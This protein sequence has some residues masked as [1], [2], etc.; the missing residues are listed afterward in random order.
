MPLDDPLRSPDMRSTNGHVR[1]RHLAPLPVRADRPD[2]EPEVRGD[3]RGRPPL[4]LGVGRSGR[5]GASMAKRPDR[6]DPLPEPGE[7]Y[8]RERRDQ[9]AGALVDQPSS[10]TGCTLLTFPGDEHG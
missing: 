2:L 7:S 10:R 5:H 4:S 1:R 8:W 3:V 6:A 9:V